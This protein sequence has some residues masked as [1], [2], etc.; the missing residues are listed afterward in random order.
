MAGY[1][2][3]ARLIRADHG[4]CVVSVLRPNGTIASSLVNA[5][6]LTHPLT[7][8]PVVG[9]VSR[10]DTRKLAYLRARPRANV[11]ARAGW[12][13]ACAEGPAGIIGPDDPHPAV[14][15]ER[16]RQL[17][18][19]VFASAGGTHEDWDGYD[20]VMAAERRAVILVTPDR[21]TG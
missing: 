3:F 6:T 2:E 9:F 21:I 20:R 13:W 12:E 11:V 15:A 19:E 5:G 14:D 7:G 17:L 1:E 18:R 10:G 8:A 16:L 4:L